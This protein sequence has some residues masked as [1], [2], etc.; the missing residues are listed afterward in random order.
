MQQTNKQRD[1]QT[2]TEECC[3]Q[4]TENETSDKAKICY[5]NNCAWIWEISLIFSRIC[6]N[7]MRNILRKF[8]RHFE[9]LNGIILNGIFLNGI[10]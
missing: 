6:K 5:F 4:Q 1:G 9:I 10:F 8:L 3:R 7:L 2:R